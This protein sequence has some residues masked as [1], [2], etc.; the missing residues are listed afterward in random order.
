MRYK[1]TDSASTNLANDFVDLEQVRS[2]LDQLIDDFESQY[3]LEGSKRIIFN[4][5]INLFTYTL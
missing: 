4:T 3:F 1:P 2:F 5:F